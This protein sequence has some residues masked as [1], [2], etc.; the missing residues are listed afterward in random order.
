MV[1]VYLE[2]VVVEGWVAVAALGLEVVV[3]VGWV[4]ASL[5]VG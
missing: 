4:V 5:G 2:V 1:Y 3:V